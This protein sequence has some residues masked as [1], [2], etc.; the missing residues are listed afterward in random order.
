MSD[1][2][3][4]YI[5]LCFRLDGTAERYAAVFRA[6]LALRPE[7]QP[8]ELERSSDHPK[9]PWIDARWSDVAAMCV[10]DEMEAWW[11]WANRSSIIARRKADQVEIELSL[12]R[13]PRDPADEL[14][15][16]IDMLGERNGPAL[17]MAFDIESKLDGLFA[18]QGLDN[19]ADVPPVLFIDWAIVGALGNATALRM[20]ANVQRVKGGLLAIVRPVFGKPGKLGKQER[21]HSKFLAGLLE[22]PRSFTGPL[23]AAEQAEEMD[24]EQFWP[25]GSY[26]VFRGVWST[27]AENAWLVGIDGQIAQWDGYDGKRDWNLVETGSEASLR[28]VAGVDDDQAWAVGDDGAI[29]EW[30][31][32]RWSRIPEVVTT[33]LFGVHAVAR[34]RA[35]AVG[36]S[37][38]ILRLADGTWHVE[39]SG[40]TRD[41]TGVSGHWIVGA[42]GTILV[43]E[44]DVWRTIT[45]AVDVVLHAVSA[46]GERE[47]WAVGERGVILHL[48]GGR[49]KVIAS[50]VDV[51]LRGV[52]AVASDNVWVV[53]DAATML[54]W[55]GRVWSRIETT[56][57]RN[58]QAVCAFD[59]RHA[60]VVGEQMELLR[61]ARPSP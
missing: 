5:K 25:E 26:G 2:Q 6:A 3:R 29:L 15:M 21:E 61:V 42:G 9:E 38:T 14:A 52:S 41:L 49:A 18:W 60:W 1:A 27:N 48:E 36:A 56:P 16:L 20:F 4:F 45:A 53:G 50:G 55:N 37:G 54:H 47:A 34:D 32:T 24:V 46:I 28:A 58:L 13:G 40:T 11:L 33:A 10:R 59:E 8:I 30:D 19:L 22:L 44:G 35:I 17:A 57:V 31:G 43:R 12:E 39:P 23:M 51:A 7:L